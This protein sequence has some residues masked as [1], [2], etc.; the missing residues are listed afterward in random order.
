MKSGLNK[1]V[2]WRRATELRRNP[3]QFQLNTKNVEMFASVG[4]TTELSEWW[5]LNTDQVPGDQTRTL[6]SLL[7]SGGIIAVQACLLLS[8]WE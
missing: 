6:L 5:S 1:S 4:V 7:Y 2:K 8:L 3:S